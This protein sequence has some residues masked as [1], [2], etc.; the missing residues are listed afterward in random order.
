MFNLLK[1][2][3]RHPYRPVH[4]NVMVTNPDYVGLT[5]QLHPDDDPYVKTDTTC[6]VKIDMVLHFTP[7]KNKKNGSINDDHFVKRGKQLCLENQDQ[8][9]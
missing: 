1:I 4:I 5:A 3:A 2:M 7:V 9:C 8:R 6:D